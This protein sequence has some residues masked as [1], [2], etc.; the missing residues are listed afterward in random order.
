MGSMKKYLIDREIAL[1]EKKISIIIPAYNV[2]KYIAKCLDSV[3]NQCYKNLDVI[4][5]D[6]G[7][8]DRTGCIIDDYS[9]KDNRIRVVHQPNGGL[10]NARNTGIKYANGDYVMFLDS[11]D[12]IEPTCCKVIVSEIQKDKADL[13]FFEYYKEYKNKTVQMKTYPHKKLTYNR[14]GKQEFFLYDMRT[15]TAWGKIYSAEILHKCEYN[16][17]LRTAEDVEFNY[18]IYDRVNKAVYIQRPLLHYRILEQSAIH[19]YDSQIKDKLKPVLECLSNWLN[20]SM[21]FHEEAYYSFKAIAFLLVCQ[22]GICLNKQLSFWQKRKKI[23]ALKRDLTYKDLFSN[24]DYV[25]IPKS[26]KL[27]IIFEKMSLPSL[28]VLVISL[29]QWRE[30]R[31]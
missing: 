21:P 16:E 10:P 30:K 5:V 15:I 12:W 25:K 2:E 20:M 4:V 29:K 31:N 1:E 6:D 8:K 18:R 7:S 28:I 27:I 22:N 13:V 19:G 24:L 23:W 26:R 17:S 9:V 11:D 14:D 3:I